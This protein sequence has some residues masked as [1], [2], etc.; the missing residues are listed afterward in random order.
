MSK[1]Q[2][3]DR[4]DLGTLQ[5]VAVHR[6]RGGDAPPLGWQCHRPRLSGAHWKGWFHPPRKAAHWVQVLL[7]FSTLRQ[8][9]LGLFFS[10]SSLS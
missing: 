3:S 10:F 5:G 6:A 1:I 4:A 7:R 8:P 9:K 2:K